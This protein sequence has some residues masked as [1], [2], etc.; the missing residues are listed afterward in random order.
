MLVKST[1]SFSKPLYFLVLISLVIVLKFLSSEY[2]MLDMLY[3]ESFGKQ[4]SNARIQEILEF[5]RNWFWVEY[6]LVPITFFL[7]FSLVA[8]CL[9]I[10]T[11]L[12]LGKIK[13]KKLF[14]IALLAETVFLLPAIIKLFWFQ[15]IQSQYSLEDLQYFSPFSILS[16]VGHENVPTWGIYPLQLTNIF[17]LIYWLLLAY[18]LHLVIKKPFKESLGV[19]AASYGTGLVLW[20]V[21]ITFLTVSTGI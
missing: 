9:Y 15:L 16:I 19:V 7:K 11:L 17:E 1:Y 13:F 21:F 6:L 10:G 3:Y 12:V 14:H 18:G 2:L 8:F 4:M 5:Q 20:V